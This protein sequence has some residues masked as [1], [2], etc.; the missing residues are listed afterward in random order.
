MFA[1]RTDR[2]G[3]HAGQ[4]SFPGGRVDPGDADDL[5]AALREAQ[6]EVGL[7]P[8][9]VEPLG[10]LDDTETFATYHAAGLHGQLPFN[11]VDSV[12]FSPPTLTRTWFHQGQVQD[13][14]GM[15]GESTWSAPWGTACGAWAET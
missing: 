7:A 10:L 12:H 9:A 8:A 3:H 6:E 4:I 2:V 14:E 1:K 15:W 11:P 13:G 5:A